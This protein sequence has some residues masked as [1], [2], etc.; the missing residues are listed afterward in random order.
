MQQLY[1]KWRSDPFRISSNFPHTLGLRVDSRGSL[2][3]FHPE[4]TV[5]TEIV[6]TQAY[7]NTY[8]RILTLRGTKSKRRA[9]VLTGQPGVGVSL[10]SV[11]R[12]SP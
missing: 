2:L 11:R 5:D 10:I 8:N 4:D 3:P 9:V 7:E 1:T 6:V 12:E